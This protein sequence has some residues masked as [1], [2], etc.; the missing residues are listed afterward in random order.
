MEQM[1]KSVCVCMSVCQ[2]IC[3]SVCEHSH[4]RISWSIF[5]KIGTNEEPPQVRTRSLGYIALPLS[6][7]CSQNPYFRPRGPD[8]PCNIK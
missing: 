7:F 4:D 5:A 1:V 3:L 6:L 8:N 2:C